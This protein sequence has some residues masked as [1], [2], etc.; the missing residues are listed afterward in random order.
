MTNI[1]QVKP[2]YKDIPLDIK[3]FREASQRVLQ[4]NAIARSTSIEEMQKQIESSDITLQTKLLIEELK[5]Y[6]EAYKVED[7]VEMADA[8]ADT[9]VVATMLSFMYFGEEAIYALMTNRPGEYFADDPYETFLRAQEMVG[10]SIGFAVLASK[11]AI[12]ARDSLVRSRFNEKKVLNEVLKS[13]ESKFPK[14][15]ALLSFH[16]T[17][18][19]SEALEKEC[20]WIEENRG[21]EGV[22]WAYNSEYKVY[23]FKNSTGKIMKPS[24]FVEPNL[25]WISDK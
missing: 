22:V 12:L 15:K 8:C 25:L 3:F 17:K 13:N 10:D 11:Y 14:K 7:F 1:Q 16:E 18:D 21:H 4:W 19:I 5:E 6:T 2:F 23:V 9:F 20:N 24:S